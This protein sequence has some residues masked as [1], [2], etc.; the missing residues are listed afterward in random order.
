MRT[1]ER[2]AGLDLGGSEEASGFWVFW[3]GGA[4]FLATSAACGSPQPGWN[5]GHSSDNAGL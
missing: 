5:L 1:N 3:S 2:A 4:L